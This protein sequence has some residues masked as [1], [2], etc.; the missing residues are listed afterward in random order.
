MATHPIVISITADGDSIDAA[1]NE[2]KPIAESLP[3]PGNS[4]FARFFPTDACATPILRMRGEYPHKSYLEA[5]P[6]PSPSVISKAMR[7]GY[8]Y[9]P[10]S[11]PIGRTFTILRPLYVL[12]RVTVGG[13]TVNQTN[14][15]Y[16]LEETQ[17]IVPAGG[18]L[19]ALI[20]SDI[21]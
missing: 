11:T 15:Y 2:V 21:Q 4:T 14:Y 17:I 10:G 19:V 8:V 3:K 20:L 9:F 13:E 7:G 16:V 1:W 5:N 18:K 6:D 12:G